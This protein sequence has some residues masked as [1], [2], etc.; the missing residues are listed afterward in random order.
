MKAE[1][2]PPRIVHDCIQFSTDRQKHKHRIE[3]L[4]TLSSHIIQHAAYKNSLFVIHIQ[5]T[6]MATIAR[7]RPTIESLK[8]RKSSSAWDGQASMFES[9]TCASLDLLPC[10]H[11]TW[12][13]GKRRWIFF[14][15]GSGIDLILGLMG[16]VF[17]SLAGPC[18]LS[19]L[20][21]GNR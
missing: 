11:I 3:F 9:C 8:G 16:R 19:S 6:S 10:I 1:L 12:T 14:G 17:C 2:S 21:Y 5:N 7:S 4:N 15:L 20:A 13:M 18:A